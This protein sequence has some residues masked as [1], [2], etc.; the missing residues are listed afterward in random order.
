M[1]LELPEL[2]SAPVGEGDIEALN[3]LHARCADYVE[4]IT[5]APPQ[6]RE[7]EELYWRLPPER[8]PE[9]K[10][11]L[12]LRPREGGDLVGVVELIRDHRRRGD[13]CLSLLVMEPGWRGKGLGARLVEALFAAMR[14]EGGETA[15]LVV[16]KQNEGALRFWTRMGFVPL[17]ESVGELRMERAL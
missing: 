3:R 8:P 5:G 11:L 14:D 16:Q 6:G 15:C 13:W 4:L 1:K 17:R 9:A 7:G 12:G 10:V 2:V